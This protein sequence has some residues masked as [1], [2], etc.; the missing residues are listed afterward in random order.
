M[1]TGHRDPIV[2][3]ALQLEEKFRRHSSVTMVYGRYAQTVRS[4]D[5]TLKEVEAVTILNLL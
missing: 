2:A 1:R 4:R 3:E 5:F